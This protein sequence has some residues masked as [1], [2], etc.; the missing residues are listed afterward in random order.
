MKG[1]DLANITTIEIQEMT[2]HNPFA[3]PS[4]YCSNS[5]SEIHASS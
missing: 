1:R 4:G 2:S 3:Y 5:V